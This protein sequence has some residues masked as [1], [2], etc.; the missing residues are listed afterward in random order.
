MEPTSDDVLS[1]V[2]RLPLNISGLGLGI[3][4]RHGHVPDEAGELP[5]GQ[6][7][8]SIGLSLSGLQKLVDQLVNDGAVVEVRGGQLWD[9]ELPTAGTKAGGRYYLAPVNARKPG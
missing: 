2:S 7:L 1:L 5:V 9:L 3:A 8:A 6:W 4:A